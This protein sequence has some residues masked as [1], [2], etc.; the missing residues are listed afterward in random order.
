MGLK[1]TLKPNEKL[2]IN[3]C[4][5]QNADRRQTLT[6]ENRA[7]VIRGIDLL[8]ESEAATPTK[9]VYFFV[10]SAMLRPEIRDDITPEIQQRLGRLVPVFNVEIGG[11]LIEAANHVSAR[12]YYNALRAIKPVIAYEEELLKLFG[13][14]DGSVVAAE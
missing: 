13:D 8:D 9:E 10:Q 5:I 4:V 1:L 2:I 6:I 11:H 7:D 3:G 12:N 14:K